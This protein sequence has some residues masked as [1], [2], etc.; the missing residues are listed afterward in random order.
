MNWLQ[1]RRLLHFDGNLGGLHYEARLGIFELNTL[2]GHSPKNEISGT[3]QR[4][5][6]GTAEGSSTFELQVWESEGGAE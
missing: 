4:Q 6:R 2:E 5:L 1:L 3:V